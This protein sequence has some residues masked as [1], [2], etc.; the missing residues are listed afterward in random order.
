MEL[1][2]N[3]QTIL[4]IL[5]GWGISKRANGNAIKLAKTPNFDNLVNNCPNATLVT[6]GPLV[7]LPENQVGNSEVG[8]MNLGAGRKIQMNLPRI[9]HALSNKFFESNQKLNSR[10]NRIKN[11]GGEI[12]IIGLCS[13][14]G[15][16]SHE[17]HIFQLI[18]YLYEFDLK[19][20][21]HMILDGRDS[22]PKNA[23]NSLKKIKNIF[24]NL[25]FI[26]SISGRYYAM[27]RDERWERTELFYR[28]IVLK[29][30][31]KFDNPER[32]IKSQYDKK[33]NDEFFKPSVSK[34]YKGINSKKDGIIFM[35]FRS[36]RM[37]QISNALCDDKFQNFSTDTKSIFKSAISLVSYSKR[38]DKFIT[39][40]FPK[41]KIK[42]TIGEVVSK[43][44]LK[45]LRLSETEKYAH[46]TYFFNCGN[47][48][49]FRGED[50]KLIQ[51]PKI[52]T[53][54]L[55]PEM[56]VAEVTV[57]LINAIE[58]L[59]HDFI[60]VNFA[61]PDMVGHTGNLNAAIKACEAVDNSLKKLFDSVKKTKANLLIVADHGNCEEM[62]NFKTNQPNT[63]HTLNLVPIILISNNQNLKIRSGNLSDVAPT[64]L[65]LMKIK[66]PKEMTG[67]SLIIK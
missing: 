29:E 36:D 24:G 28:T 13:D 10:I 14:G 46:V 48:Q 43:S 17:D 22:F 52:K 39:S 62:I 63:A 55:Q 38:L 15:V 61:N 5:D 33:I 27:D 58:T 3:D 6:H 11:I 8:H 9:N 35:N 54:D 50:R 12:H 23:F 47:E 49:N 16:H 40:L 30:G 65:D 18:R 32:F 34:R 60:V 66:K 21:F 4:C 56:S 1:K 59:K 51:S 7:G 31:I 64:L 37:R 41:V 19:V 67:R 45:Q 26:S 42:N 57:S 44:G 2:K 20:H 53:Y 25:N